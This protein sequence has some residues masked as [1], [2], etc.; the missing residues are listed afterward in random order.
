[1]SKTLQEK[2]SE[3]LEV[4]KGVK[5]DEMELGKHV[6]NDDLFILLQSYETKTS[7]EARYEAH[8]NYVDI[9]YIIEGTEAIYVAPITI[10]EET[11]PYSPEKDVVFYN[12]IDQAAAAVL[13]SGGYAVLYPADAHKP[14]VM[15]D[16]PATVKK[17]VGKV[18]I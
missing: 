12:D 1:M 14:C 18:R 8:K 10:M 6:I 11:A 13:T 15:V 5:F 2:I 3:A 17:I 9:Q 4:I 7:E 16:G